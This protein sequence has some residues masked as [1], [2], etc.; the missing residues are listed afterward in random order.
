MANQVIIDKSKLKNIGDKIRSKT[1]GTSNLTV[2]QMAS[3]IANKLVKPSGNA[4]ADKVLSGYTFHS[5]DSTTIKT[6]T[7][8]SKSSSDLSVSGATVSVP[9][10]YYASPVSKSVATATQATPS[11]TI[12]S[13]TG[14]ITASATQSA[15][16]VASGTKSGTLQLDVY[17]ATNNKITPSK[18]A[19]KIPAGSYIANELTIS[20]DSDLVAKNIKKGV[21]IFNVTGTYE[22]PIDLDDITTMSWQQLSELSSKGVDLSGCLGQ[23]KNIT[24]SG[25]TLPAR[26][27][28]MKYNGTKGYVFMLA[29]PLPTK[30][31]MHTSS[32]T[33]NLTTNG[34]AGTNFKT[35]LE[36]TIF[37]SINSDLRNYMKTITLPYTKGAGNYKDS[38][39]TIGTLST[40]IFIPSVEEL[41]GRTS[42]DYYASK[43]EGKQFDY[44]ANGNSFAIPYYFGTRTKTTKERFAG[45]QA[46]ATTPSQGQWYTSG[47]YYMTPCFVI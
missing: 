30:Y 42:V 25:S 43:G 39:V 3:E 20:G 38:T 12:D 29:E 33:A 8:T 1:G 26:L 36:G 45:F 28:S 44:F 15:G 41:T 23:T 40:N 11:V 31:T 13:S 24:I 17:T 46:N 7:I 16:Y 22:T 2:D 5:G 9:S 35:T 4:T 37:N 14:L 32:N 19:T 18:S 6:G 34:W 27:V 21:K 10:G 47:A